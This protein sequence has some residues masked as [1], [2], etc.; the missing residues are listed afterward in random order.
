MPLACIDAWVD[1][2]IAR[3]ASAMTEDPAWRALGTAITEGRSR[4]EQVGATRVAEA[5]MSSLESLLSDRPEA[6][7]LLPQLGEQLGQLTLGDWERASIEAAE[8][9]FAQRRVWRTLE[10][11][12]HHAELN[13]EEDSP[14]ASM[15][16]ALDEDLGALRAD[17]LAAIDGCKAA[18]SAVASHRPVSIWPL[19]HIGS[20]RGLAE[21][22]LQ[23]I[24]DR[25]GIPRSEM[26]DVATIGDHPCF[27]V[28]EVVQP[29]EDARGVLEHRCAWA[30]VFFEL[31]DHLA[32][33]ADALDE[34]WGARKKR[35]R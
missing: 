7:D 18:R 14:W 6:R 8:P 2:V 28:I 4:H 11:C 25:T 3:V 19:E 29:L 13:G 5:V 22:S 30:E 26:L 32:P 27:R 34:R 33:L 24:T 16:E 20:A 31:R 9:T 21:E 1:R 35:K 10:D 17:L 12:W 15:A 23:A